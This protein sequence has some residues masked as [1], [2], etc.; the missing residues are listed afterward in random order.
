MVM[1]KGSKQIRAG[2]TVYVDAISATGE[3][4]RSYKLGSLV[5]YIK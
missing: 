1:Q 3:D 2:K 5:Y 4:G